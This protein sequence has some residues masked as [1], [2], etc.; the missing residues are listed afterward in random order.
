MLSIAASAAMPATGPLAALG[1]IGGIADML[2]LA[3]GGPSFSKQNA[4]YGQQLRQLATTPGG[5]QFLSQRQQLRQSDALMARRAVGSKLLSGG[6]DVSFLSGL[7]K[8]F[9]TVVSDVAPA[10]SRIGSVIHPATTAAGK[11]ATIAVDAAGTAVKAVKAHPVLAAA[12][13]AAA[14]GGMAA[15]SLMTPAGKAAHVK[16]VRQ[17]LGMHHRRMHVTNTKALH[18]ALRR[19]KGFEHVARRVLQ[20]THH[21]P[22]KVHFKFGKHRRVA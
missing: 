21:K 15:G 1:P 8:V 12:G 20:I 16:R 4:I 13:A 22:V 6:R 11:A 5:K 19:V 18:R 2:L 10:I 7:S 17:A 3:F 14:A 9:G